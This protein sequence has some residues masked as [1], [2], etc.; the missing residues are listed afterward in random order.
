MKINDIIQTPEGPAIVRGFP[1]I[2]NFRIGVRFELQATGV[3]R[4]EPR[5]I[6]DR[7]QRELT[8]EPL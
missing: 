4:V 5:F 8:H 2:I 7:W 1:M 3:V 6:V